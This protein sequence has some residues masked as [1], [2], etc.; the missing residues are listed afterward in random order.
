MLLTAYFVIFNVILIKF[1]IVDPVT[2]L[3]SHITKPDDTEQINKYIFGIKKREYDKMFKRQ[4]WIDQ[5]ERA[6]KKR[7]RKVLMGMVKKYHEGKLTLN[8]LKKYN[9]KINIPGTY[10]ITHIDEVEELKI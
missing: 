1:E 7:M 10:E 4:I 6:R 5:Q 9:D 3:I 8:E 2:Q